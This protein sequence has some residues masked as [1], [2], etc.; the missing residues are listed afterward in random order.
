MSGASGVLGRQLVPFFYASGDGRDSGAGESQL[1]GCYHAPASSA[2]AR[3]VGLVLCQ[4]LGHEYVQF[5]RV[6]RQLAIMLA[7]AGFAVLRFDFAGC[8]DS[9]GD[10]ECWS[11]Q[12]WRDDIDASLDELSRRSG[13]TTL[14]LVGLRLG[15]TLALQVAAARDDVASVVSWD[16]VCS[17]RAYVDELVA[18]HEAMLAYAHVRP[19]MDPLGAEREEILGFPMPRALVDEL[20]ALDLSA[21]DGAPGRS[22]MVIESH[23]AVAQQPLLDLLS[24]RPLE[25]T[26]ERF[27]NP[28]LWVWTEDFAKVHIP[29]KIL[30]GI[31][32]WA[33]EQ[34]GA[35]LPGAASAGDDVGMVP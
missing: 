4:P 29:R 28:H 25:L 22:V 18:Q 35:R 7:D 26:H 14:G 5:H 1:F 11:V 21:L 17:G 19:D 10:H 30:Q 24:E 33:S 16:A 27:S 23:D 6:F 13:V 20:V 15:A 8:G 12:R 34:A 32:T 3:S 31:V 9:S 2:P